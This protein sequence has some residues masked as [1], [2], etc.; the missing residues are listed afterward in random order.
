MVSKLVQFPTRWILE[1]GTLLFGEEWSYMLRF[2][3]GQEVVHNGI[4]FTVVS[5]NWGSFYSDEHIITLR[6]TEEG[7]S[8]EPRHRFYL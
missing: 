6:L 3:V 5:D 8:H 2:R 1:D 4:S 7:V